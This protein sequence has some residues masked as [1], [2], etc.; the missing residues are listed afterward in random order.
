MANKSASYSTLEPL[1]LGDIGVHGA[2]AST[3]ISADNFLNECA[4]ARMAAEIFKK[5]LWGGDFSKWHAL[6][7]SVAPY[8]GDFSDFRLVTTMK[9]N[10][11][12]GGK[13]MLAA[14]I[15]AKYRNPE[16]KQIEE[17]DVCQTGMWT[18]WMVAE[19]A[20]FGLDSSR[21]VHMLK[22]NGH[23]M[24]RKA[25]GSFDPA[26]TDEAYPADTT[27]GGRSFPMDKEF[28]AFDATCA[29]LSKCVI[30]G[31]LRDS[32]LKAKELY[33]KGEDMA[34]PPTTGTT[35]YDA[36]AAEEALRYLHEKKPKNLDE[37]KLPAEVE[38]KMGAR[39]LKR[40]QELDSPE[41]MSHPELQDSGSSID[42]G[43]KT[44]P[45]TSSRARPELNLME[46]QVE[47][48]DDD[49][50]GVVDP[51]QARRAAAPQTRAPAGNTKKKTVVS[52]KRE[53]AKA[54][55]DFVGYEYSRPVSVA[56]SLAY[57]RE[58]KFKPRSGPKA[59]KVSLTWAMRNPEGKVVLTPVP[60]SDV[61]CRWL[62]RRNAILRTRIVPKISTK[63]KGASM[64]FNIMEVQILGDYSQV[65]SLGRSTPIP[66]IFGTRG[67]G[68]TR[69]LPTGEDVA[70]LY[71]EALG[72]YS[73]E[74]LKQLQEAELLYYGEAKKPQLAITA[75]GD[76]AKTKPPTDTKGKRAAPE[77]TAQ[78]AAK[79][80]KASAPAPKEEE[81]AGAG[82]EEAEA[83]PEGDEEAPAEE[84]AAGEEEEAMDENY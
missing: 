58:M 45:G 42:D 32:L 73:A 6:C 34:S 39:V 27:K 1:T 69:N 78:P 49:D 4:P 66:P 76:D 75:P 81:A 56:D 16:T 63:D 47:N 24:A 72:E 74:D 14:Q 9:D 25:D 46:S 3:V 84:E 23:P 59:V 36:G 5:I 38:K 31:I 60:I 30:D 33:A 55:K 2:R 7:A 79:K 40:F 18:P 57:F 52:W 19:V 11:Y 62:A 64:R 70:N 15:L 61:A 65:M 50:S 44:I 26:F 83:A 12:D 68:Q 22:A 53:N 43:W 28:S 54:F 51:T 41:F 35:F 8:S 29:A 67:P 48:G 80:S 71:L 17:R 10:K 77:E 21:V 82:E 13:L 37:V 20:S